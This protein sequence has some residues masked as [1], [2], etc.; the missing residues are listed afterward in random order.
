M[1]IIAL[2]GFQGSGKDTMA[3]ILVNK[4]N[5]IKLS[6]ATATKDVV[7][8]IFQWDRN[9]VEG[10]TVESR[11][12]REKVDDWWSDRLGIPNFT[13]RMALQLIGT[14]LFRNK[15]FDDI[16]VSI[17]EKKIINLKDLN[18]NV[19][20]VIT[21]CR[22]PNEIEMVKRH[23]AKLIHIYRILPSWFND[24]KLGMDKEEV[25]QLHPSE[26]SWIRSEFDYEIM[27]NKTIKDLEKE[28]DDIY[29]R[30]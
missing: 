4:Y 23:N 7:S 29:L 26:T 2:C 20:I 6:F 8:D 9:M 12:L 27:N 15:F 22:F 5:F 16:W 17:V 3:D 30:N 19:N 24:Y 21:D 1:K 18:E 25:H 28:I 10:S 14:D 13:P 11:Q